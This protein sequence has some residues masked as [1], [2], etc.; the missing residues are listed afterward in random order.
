MV[1]VED[2]R[3]GHNYICVK[4]NTIVFTIGEVYPCVR[5][6][7]GLFLIPD[8]NYPQRVSGLISK[9]REEVLETIPL[10]EML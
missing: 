3:E 4:A 1:K 2:F 7:E 6:K 10:E 8:D 5:I 9:F